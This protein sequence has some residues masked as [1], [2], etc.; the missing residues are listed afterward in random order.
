MT[1]VSGQDRG[2]VRDLVYTF[3]LCKE[4]EKCG[5]LTTFITELSTNKI[6]SIDFKFYNT[7][8]SQKYLLILK[9]ENSKC[10]KEFLLYRFIQFILLG[11]MEIQFRNL[12][13][14]QF[15]PFMMYLI[16]TVKHKIIYVT[17]GLSY[18]SNIK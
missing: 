17:Q 6:T 13:M 3:Q 2:E 9:N 1:E 14:F 16:R 15:M 7:F 8:C 18:I 5:M 10:P 4:R 11:R 12:E